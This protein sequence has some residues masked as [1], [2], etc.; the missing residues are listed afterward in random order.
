M[1]T[2]KSRGHQ[3]S[4]EGRVYFKRLGKRIARLREAKS[5]SQAELGQI[6]G[7]SEEQVAE[8]ECGERR[9]PL[10]VMPALAAHLGISISDLVD[11][12]QLS[13][14]PKNSDTWKHSKT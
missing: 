12:E 11:G 5:Q 3:I 1:D 8:V 7:I 2:S 14:P 9:P 13:L 6:L 4:R 10:S